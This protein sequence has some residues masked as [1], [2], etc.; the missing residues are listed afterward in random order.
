MEHPF[1]SFVLRLLETFLTLLSWADLYWLTIT[2]YGQ[3][4]SRLATHWSFLASIP[5]AYLVALVIHVISTPP[6]SM[7]LQQTDIG[8]A[9][10]LCLPLARGL[11]RRRHSCNFWDC[12]DFALYLRD[13]RN[14]PDFYP[15]L[16]PRLLL[17]R[18]LDHP[19]ISHHVH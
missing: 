10:I 14:C 16:P 8:F 17:E 18:A 6:Q 9:A 4:V 13:F 2:N 1:R 11:R 15:P 3:P 12:G 7:R 19:R 5:L